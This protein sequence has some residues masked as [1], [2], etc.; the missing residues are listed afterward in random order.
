M[1]SNMV[2]RANLG[3][4]KMCLRVW[5]FSKSSYSEPDF[6]KKKKKQIQSVWNLSLALNLQRT[7]KSAST[8]PKSAQETAL[9]FSVKNAQTAH[10]FSKASCIPG[11]RIS[12]ASK[13]L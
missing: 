12:V 9:I 5:H 10:L 2:L 6:F 3:H 11:C 7:V 1:S 8:N 4:R 13:I